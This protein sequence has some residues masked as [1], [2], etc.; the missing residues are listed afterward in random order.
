M[1]STSV[2]E[3]STAARCDSE[4]SMSLRPVSAS[5]AARTERTSVS[6]RP[7]FVIVRTRYMTASTRPQ[8]RLQPRAAANIAWI[9]SRPALATDTAPTKVSAMNRPKSSSD[10]RST[11]LSTGSRTFSTTTSLLLIAI[12]SR[13]DPWIRLLDR[14]VCIGRLFRTGRAASRPPAPAAPDTVRSPCARR[15]ACARARIS[16]PAPPCARPRARRD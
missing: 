12:G 8:A 14:A 15:T 9:S 10:T 2:D 11:G 5:G 4:R 3:T 6:D 13:L 1:P 7:R 16:G